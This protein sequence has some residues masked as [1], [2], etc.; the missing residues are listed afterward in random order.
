LP[1]LDGRVRK[2]VAAAGR[3]RDAD[4]RYPRARGSNQER[5]PLSAFGGDG[6]AQEDQIE[7]T[8][9]EL[10]DSLSDGVCGRDVVSGRLPD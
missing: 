3:V 6:M 1:T 10:G 2:T 5:E 4:H 9:M 8:L 7:V